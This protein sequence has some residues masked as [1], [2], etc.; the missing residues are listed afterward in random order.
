MILK[1]LFMYLKTRKWGALSLVCLCISLLSG[2]V[3][4]LQYDPA[5]PYYAT[6]AMD[7]LVPFGMYFRSLH[8]YSSQF[9]FLLA[10]IHLVTAFASTDTYTSAQWGRLVIAL[11]VMLLLLFTGYVLRQDSTGSSAG[12]IAES[13][14]M[15]IP[16]LGPALNDALFSIADH[17]M[18]R[19]YVSHIITLDLLWLVLAWEHLRRYRIRFTDHLPAAGMVLLFSVFITA[20]LDPEKLGVTYISGPWFFLGLQELLRYLPP[21]LAG[22][23][24][25]ALFILALFFTQKRYSFFTSVLTLLAIWLFSYLILTAM[26]LTH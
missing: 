10:I 23:L 3:V 4:A 20:P 9:F 25:P 6:A 26:A 14:L 18:Q 7:L 16:V 1:T 24:F 13:I 8:F 17:G 21:L 19:V 5:N 2:L 12:F 15:A 22:F 11:P